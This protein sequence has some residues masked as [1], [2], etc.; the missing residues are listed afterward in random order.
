MK[1][2]FSTYVI[3][4]A[5]LGIVF[6]FLGKRASNIETKK[7]VDYAA[8]I[9]IFALMYIY[10]AAPSGFE[11]WPVGLILLPIMLIFLFLTKRYISYCQECGKRIQHLGNDVSFCPKCGASLKNGL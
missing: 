2:D 8:V 10:I 3:L 5:I 4:W 11:A 7:K 1:I 6:H 9:S